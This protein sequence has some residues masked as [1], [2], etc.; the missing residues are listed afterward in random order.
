MGAAVRIGGSEIGGHSHGQ[1]NNVYDNDFVGCG[2]GS[3]KVITENQGSICGNICDEGNCDP[4]GAAL[5]DI[6]DTWDQAC[7]DDED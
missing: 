7:D 1:S 5:G 6:K 3:V 4:F 2:E